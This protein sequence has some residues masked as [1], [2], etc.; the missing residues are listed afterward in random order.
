MRTKS[1]ISFW[2]SLLCT[3]F[4]P[5]FCP[6]LHLLYFAPFLV[7]C[8]Y[9]YSR[10]SALWRAIGCGVI[11]DLLSSTHFFGLTSINYSL[12]TLLLYGQTRHFFEDKLSTLPLMSSLFS[13]FSTAVAFLLTIFF[14]HRFLPSWRWIVTDL[15]GMSLIDGCYAFLLFSLPF[16]LTYRIRKMRSHDHFRK[17]H[18]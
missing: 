6:R 1:K 16:H 7:T 8:S 2:I 10:F 13:F 9:K 12:V 4:A 14:G 17:S 5:L 3:L 11:I 15:F 18:S